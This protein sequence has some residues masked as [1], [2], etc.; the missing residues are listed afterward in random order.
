VIAWLKIWFSNLVFALKCRAGFRLLEY[1]GSVTGMVKALE[2]AEDGDCCFDL[3]IDGPPS[4]LLA[5]KTSGATHICETL[6]CEI[7]PADRARLSAEIAKLKIGVRVRV[8]GRRAWDGCHHGKGLL[9]DALMV[10]LGAAPTLDGWIECHPC[11]SLEVL[12]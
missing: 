1:I 9:F 11:T 12:Q 6:H 10:L 7:V 8:S 2:M 3:V 5:Y 4:P